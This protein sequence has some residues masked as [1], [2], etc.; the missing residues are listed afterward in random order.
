MCETK[1]DMSLFSTL[2]VNL[3]A[4]KFE[5]DEPPCCNGVEGPPW[6]PVM[7]VPDP[8]GGTAAPGGGRLASCCC[9]G[10]ELGTL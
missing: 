7:S 8:L 3:G 5:S 6:E 1:I 4:F 10:F 9:D 2:P